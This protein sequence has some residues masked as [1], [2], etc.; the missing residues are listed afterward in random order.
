MIKYKIR[1]SDWL[2]FPLI[3]V[4]FNHF[5][6][7]PAPELHGKEIINAFKVDKK[8]FNDVVQLTLLLLFNNTIQ[9]CDTCLDSTILFDPVFV[10]LEQVIIFCSLC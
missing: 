5:F 3:I 4:N 7:Q 9:H 8:G 6:I 1:D 10:N 2:K